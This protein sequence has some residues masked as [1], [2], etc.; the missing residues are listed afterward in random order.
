VFVRVTYYCV[1]LL[2]H[3]ACSFVC[4]HLFLPRMRCVT[5]YLNSLPN[6][7]KCLRRWTA[8]GATACSLENG[9]LLCSYKNGAIAAMSDPSGNASIMDMSGRCMLLLSDRGDATVYDRRGNIIAT[10][11]RPVGIAVGMGS[12]GEDIAG[13]KGTNSNSSSTVVSPAQDDV[14]G[15]D[16]AP[17]HKWAFDDMTFNF[18]PLNWEVSKVQV[19]GALRHYLFLLRVLFRS[20]VMCVIC[21]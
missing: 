15:K 3:G 18:N 5:I 16:K 20:N 4:V 2:F 13:D 12:V 14:R 10:Y 17:R 9:K 21:Y 6:N 1:C 11:Q 19:I 8:Y 7:M